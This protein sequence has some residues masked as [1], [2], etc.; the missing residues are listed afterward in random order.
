MAIL[1]T[2]GVESLSQAVR[3]DPIAMRPPA[4]NGEVLG[5][6]ID[7]AVDSLWI[8]RANQLRVQ[9]I[10]D[11]LTRYQALTGQEVDRGAWQEDFLSRFVGQTSPFYQDQLTNRVSPYGPEAPWRLLGAAL[12]EKVSQLPPDQQAQFNTNYEATVEAAFQAA[13]EDYQAVLAAASGMGKFL[14][15]AGVLAGAALDPAMLA[16][17]VVGGWAMIPRGL[18]LGRMVLAEAGLGAALELAVT[19]QVAEQ[20]ELAGTDFGFFDAAINIIFAGVAS[21]GLAAAGRGVSVAAGRLRDLQSG[22]TPDTRLLLD[23]LAQRLDEANLSPISGGRGFEAVDTFK[24]LDDATRAIA[25]GRLVEPMVADVDSVTFTAITRVMTTQARAVARNIEDPELRSAF[26]NTFEDAQVR[27]GEELKKLDQELIDS[28]SPSGTTFKYTEANTTVRS[29]ESQ[30][31]ELDTAID[32]LREGDNP[33][34]LLLS[35]FA[36]DQ[37]TAAR[38][39]QIGV[40]LEQPGLTKKARTALETERDSILPTVQAE[41]DDA[42]LT[43]LSKLRRQRQDAS[44]KRRDLAEQIRQTPEY[45]ELRAQREQAVLQDVNR[46]TS[47]VQTGRME[48]SAL[49]PELAQSGYRIMM[50]QSREFL[51]QITDPEVVR[52]ADEARATTYAP[53]PVARAEGSTEPLPPTPPKGE[54]H[55]S[56]GEGV[57]I[58]SLD[59]IRTEIEEGRTFLKEFGACISG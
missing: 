20:Q 7:Y 27:I 59:S 57:E 58:R 17:S 35:R 3:N 52:V 49:S 37:V 31:A 21:G 25:E 16:M 24:S 41:I 4:S 44:R 18:T 47:Q 55:L 56:E 28:V 8:G 2:Y 48:P 36:P 23:A 40:E 29:L 53:E 34:L 19:P 33:N 14:G 10:E 42:A 30:I 1:D 12:A 51:D 6:G 45:K 22:V 43:A 46:L 11:Q 15:A 50:D 9:A 26:E 39:E 5:A 13:G 54:V 38:L 32:R